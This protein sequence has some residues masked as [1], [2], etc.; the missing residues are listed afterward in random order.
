MAASLL[1]RLELGI[2]VRA[3]SALLGAVTFAGTLAGV[4]LLTGRARH[5]ARLTSVMIGLVVLS[6]GWFL[7]LP[8]ILA[9]ATLVDVGRP[10][11]PP[12]QT[13]RAPRPRA[14]DTARTPEI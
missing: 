10:G 7:L 3:T 8:A 1:A 14:R 5:G 9:G 4:R 11:T 13:T 6:C 12:P 2:L